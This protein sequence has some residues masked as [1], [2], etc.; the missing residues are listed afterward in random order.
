MLSRFPITRRLYSRKL[1]LRRLT[2][3]DADNYLALIRENTDH[4]RPWL[5]AFPEK[6]SLNAA[7]YWI[8]EE[9]RAIRNNERL[10]LGIF[11]LNTQKL[12]GRIALHSI[13]MG[14]QRSAGVSYWLDK[15]FSNQGLMT[16]ALATLI[17]FSFE[18]GSF[19]R[20][21]L[22][23]SVNNEPSIA[24]S[25]KLGFRE[26][27]RRKKELFI[28]G[29]WQDTIEMAILEEEYEKIA[30]SWIKKGYLGA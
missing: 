13:I 30:D 17:S 20:I 28:D 29:N 19:H 15:N 11:F 21:W 23:I 24:L 8:E 2:R 1:E 27:G 5:P 25:K 6:P 14:I 22:S 16:Q 18:E 9:H 10:D 26:E 3:K 12:I 7:R 4:L